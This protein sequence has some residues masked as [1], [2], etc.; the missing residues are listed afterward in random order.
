[1]MLYSYHSINDA[2]HK[3]Q[4]AGKL[5]N[6]IVELMNLTSE[7]IAFGYERIDQQ[8]QNK[9]NSI[10]QFSEQNSD[11]FNETKTKLISLKDSYLLMRSF[12]LHI[13]TNSG[14]NSNDAEIIKDKLAI[15]RLSSHIRIT[16]KQILDEA[17]GIFDR[18]L[19]EHSRLHKRNS[20]MIIG[21]LGILILFIALSVRNH[22]VV[23]KNEI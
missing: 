10:Y 7:W 4:I 16:S 21:F 2:L 1:M 8:W 20:L 17:S 13:N 23:Y 14:L 22:R 9:Y 18:S 6:E 5:E 15:E 11:I 12:V 19:E 3:Q